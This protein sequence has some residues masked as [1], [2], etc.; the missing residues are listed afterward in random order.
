MGAVCTRHSSQ[1]TQ[2]EWKSRKQTA[3]LTN[4]VAEVSAAWC[5]TDLAMQKTCQA[6]S[7]SRQVCLRQTSTVAKY[8]AVVTSVDMETEVQTNV[9]GHTVYIHYLA[10][11]AHFD[12]ATGLNPEDVVRSAAFEH[13]TNVSLEQADV[14]LADRRQLP[15]V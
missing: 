7:C 3:Q 13:F 2:H 6:I 1:G 15:M 4:I 14:A 9:Q 11:V 8:I 12:S 5:A 10:S